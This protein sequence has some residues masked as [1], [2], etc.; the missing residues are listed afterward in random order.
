MER[1]PHQQLHRAFPLALA[2]LR[3]Q[4][5]TGMGHLCCLKGSGKG[6]PITLS[7]SDSGRTFFLWLCLALGPG[8][9]LS[10]QALLVQSSV[11][12]ALL[13]E[14]D[15][16]KKRIKIAVHGQLFPDQLEA[17]A[18]LC[19]LR[20]QTVLSHGWQD[21]FWHRHGC[22]RHPDTSLKRRNTNEVTSSETNSM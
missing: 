21:P 4:C 1:L 14:L 22:L 9:Q 20:G 5:L 3:N 11:T 6:T 7:E 10:A 17:Y 19:Q 8:F 15:R 18:C 2:F 13:I 16:E 12:V